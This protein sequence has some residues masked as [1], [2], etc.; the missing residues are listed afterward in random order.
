MGKSED[1]TE[2]RPWGKIVIVAGLVIT[3]LAAGQFFG[4]AEYLKSLVEQI[5]KLGALGALIFIAVYVV[6]TVLLLPASAL[7]LAAG[8]VFGLF[9]GYIYV[10]IGSVLG[11]AG[12]FRHWVQKQIAG[13]RKFAAVDEAVAQEGWKIVALTRLSP[14]FPFNLLNYA[15]G[16]TKIGFF[17]YIIASWIA[18]IPGTLMYVYL[19]SLVKSPQGRSPSQWALLIVGL[20]ATIGATVLITRSAKK[21]LNRKLED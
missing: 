10:S 20:L 12:A 9:W 18:M 11:A 19:G 13:N 6:A 4:V 15:F 8:A 2:Q 5:E 21:A 3:I 14:A 17:P 1:S 7:T 16:L